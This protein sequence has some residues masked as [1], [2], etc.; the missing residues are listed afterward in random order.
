[1]PY[2]GSSSPPSRMRVNPTASAEEPL[3]HL[4]REKDF[5]A[6]KSAEDKLRQYERLVEG[7]DEM[8]AVVDRKYRCVLTNRA[9]HEV[10]AAGNESIE[11]R[12]IPEFVNRD[13]FERVMVPNLDECFSG[14]SV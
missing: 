12:F 3:R 1:M 10:F 8:V 5:T 2:R 9:F 13:V 6:R 14:K 4:R 11:G 7:L